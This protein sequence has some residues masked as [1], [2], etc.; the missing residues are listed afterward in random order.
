[1]KLIGFF[2]IEYE[3]YKNE[4]IKIFKVNKF[5]FVSF[6]DSIYEFCNMQNS[7]NWIFNLKI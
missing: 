7:D 6:I 4:L 3:I 1:M 5:E 2:I